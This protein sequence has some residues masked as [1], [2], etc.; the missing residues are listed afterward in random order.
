MYF[1]TQFSP[2]T[3]RQCIIRV[4]LVYLL[5]ITRIQINLYKG[6]WRA[7]KAAAQNLLT[8]QNMG[9]TKL[10]TKNKKKE[11]SKFNCSVRARRWFYSTDTCEE[12]GQR[13][14]SSKK[15]KKK[16]ILGQRVYNTRVQDLKAFHNNTNKAMYCFLI[17]VRIINNLRLLDHDKVSWRLHTL[18]F[19]LFTPW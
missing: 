12:T 3:I 8:P 17:D 18:S 2:S 13:R 4:H 6:A 7:E 9:G 19:A 14:V 10:N 15:K 1:S 5:I 16:K 11:S